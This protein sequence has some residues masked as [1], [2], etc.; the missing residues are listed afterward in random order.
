M[1]IQNYFVYKTPIGKLTIVSDGTSIT[2]IAFGE[3]K[4]PGA[5]KAT[6]LTNKA[7]TQLLQYFAGKRTSF[8]FPISAQGSAFQQAVWDV[9]SRIPYGQTRSYGQVAELIGN[10]KAARAV[11]IANNRNPLPIVVPCHRVIGA[12]GKPVGYAG[13]LKLKEYLLE[14]EKNNS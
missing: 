13:G 9:V 6:T 11:G 2:N 12:N 10:K 1:S 5:K 3:K 8:D 4:F 7:S 14:L